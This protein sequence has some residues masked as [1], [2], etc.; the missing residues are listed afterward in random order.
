M[1]IDD[2]IDRLLEREAGYV[3]HPADRGGPTN[4]GITQATLAAWRRQ[5]V[6][7]FQ[8]QALSKDEARA[9]Y[10]ANYFERPGL[11]CVP[12]PQ[13]QELLFDWAVNAGPAAAVKG[14]QKAVGAT[15]DGAIGPLTRA[16]VATVANWEALFYRLKALRAEQFM[17]ILADAS[18]AVFAT[19]W[20]NRLG[21]FDY[22]R[23]A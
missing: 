12:D 1:T 3:N 2:L 13:V 20:A 7:E 21:E 9:I 23:A 6:S 15:P 4:F 17:R 5:P 16:A 10:R 19:G 22:R 8:V 14:L 18:Q 11:D